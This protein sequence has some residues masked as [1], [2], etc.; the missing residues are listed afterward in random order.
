MMNKKAF[1]AN[2]EYSSLEL[3]TKKFI[4]NNILEEGRVGHIYQSCFGVLAAV[5]ILDGCGQDYDRMFDISG[6]GLAV[7]GGLNKGATELSRK[8]YNTV[9]KYILDAHYIAR[10]INLPHDYSRIGEHGFKVNNVIEKNHM[11]DQNPRRKLE[12]RSHSLG[13]AP[14]EPETTDVQEA[15]WLMSKLTT[16]LH[17]PRCVRLIPQ[18]RV[19]MVTV[20]MELRVHLS[21]KCIG[22]MC[23]LAGV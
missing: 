7:R 6:F 8:L 5:M 15:R 14:S 1:F 23:H 19:L 22:P 3:A 10:H 9:P 2:I 20:V 11:L 13:K 21:M 17:L 18:F 16:R 12:A 4:E